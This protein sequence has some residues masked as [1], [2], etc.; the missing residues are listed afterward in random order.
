MR[1]WQLSL[2]SHLHNPPPIVYVQGGLPEMEAE[3]IDDDEVYLPCSG[4]T[5]DYSIGDGHSRLDAQEAT[6]LAG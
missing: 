4:T 3:R 6:H 1:I 5:A 2:N